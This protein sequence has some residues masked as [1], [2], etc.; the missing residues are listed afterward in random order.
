MTSYAMSG[1]KEKL[2]AEGCSAYIEKPI[3]PACVVAQIEAA[4]SSER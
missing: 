4:L 2:L 3:D 1:D